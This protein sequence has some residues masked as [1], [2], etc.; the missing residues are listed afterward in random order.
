M[1]DIAIEEYNKKRKMET[2]VKNKEGSL[3]NFWACTFAGFVVFMFLTQKRKKMLVDEKY[4][5][6]TI[7]NR[8]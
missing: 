3:F 4:K 6:L 8:S 7:I 2:E 1:T 5:K